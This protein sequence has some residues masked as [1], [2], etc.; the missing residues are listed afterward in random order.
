MKMATLA[1]QIYQNQSTLRWAGKGATIRSEP[2]AP[3][4]DQ[5]TPELES[6]VRLWDRRMGRATL[7]VSRELASSHTPSNRPQ[8]RPQL[9]V[10]FPSLAAPLR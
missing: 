5:P 10:S 3:P 8:T 1:A 7:P 9:W 4:A 6:M 2:N